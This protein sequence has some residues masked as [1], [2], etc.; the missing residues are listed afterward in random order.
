VDSV[1]ERVYNC[2]S[3]GDGKF[4]NA[5]F[6]GSIAV[7][8]SRRDFNLG[9][10]FSFLDPFAKSYEKLSPDEVLVSKEKLKKLKYQIFA[11]GSGHI[12]IPFIIGTGAGWGMDTKILLQR[13]LV[14]TR[15]FNGDAERGISMYKVYF[16]ALVAASWNAFAGDIVVKSR[17]AIKLHQ[18][19]YDVNS[20]ISYNVLASD[21]LSDCHQ[22]LFFQQDLLL[23]IKKLPFD[24]FYP[25]LVVS[26][27]ADKHW[28]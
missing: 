4:I 2:N 22:A 12:L 18:E 8:G 20:V 5:H 21:S 9:I 6:R 15:D 23:F 14:G 1:G 17:D 27:V 11:T 24:G 19:K 7:Y 13:F 3:S 28:F 25:L 16:N 10:N 26:R